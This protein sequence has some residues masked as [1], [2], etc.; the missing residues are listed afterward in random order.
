[1]TLPVIGYAAVLLAATV[2]AAARVVESKKRDA[3]DC[4]LGHLVD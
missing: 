2:A 4:A 1:M 3:V